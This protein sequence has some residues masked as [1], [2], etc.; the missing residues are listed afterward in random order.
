MHTGCLFRHYI[1]RKRLNFFFNIWWV[2]HGRAEFKLILC[3]CLCN[4]VFVGAFR[5][6]TEKE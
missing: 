1:E 3:V 2:S 5:I 6:K 4:H